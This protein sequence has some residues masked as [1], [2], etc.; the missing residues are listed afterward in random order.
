MPILNSIT[1]SLAISQIL[2]FAIFIAIHHR[3]SNIAK[4]LILFCVCF[5][6]YLLTTIPSIVSNAYVSFVLYRFAVAS[7]ALIWLVAVILFT[8]THRVPRGAIVLIALYMCANGTGAFLFYIQHEFRPTTF[9]LTFVIAQFI[10]L[11]FAVHA[12]YLG[13]T[14]KTADLIEAR[15]NVRLPFVIA[16][17]AL[18]AL[19]IGTGFL[20][21]ALILYPQG[22]D[23]SQA[24]YYSNTI[25]TTV[26]FLVCLLLNIKTFSLHS[27]ATIL[28][29]ERITVKPYDAPVPA[30]LRKS[31]DSDLIQRIKHTMEHEKLYREM[32]FTLGRLSEHLS[33][34]DY[35]LRRAIN[36]KLGF[37]NFNQFLNHFRIAEASEL[38]ER[39]SVP[40][41]T[42]ALNVG[43]ASL[44]SFNKAFKEQHGIP[45]RDYRVLDKVSESPKENAH[46]A[47]KKAD[48]ARNAS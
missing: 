28:L 6:S 3:E 22:N 2:F 48:Y 9:F 17:G 8:D 4:L 1:A 20:N 10:M 14:G 42:I 30:S 39:T 33:V 27:N 15:R 7:P 13:I 40:I 16:M 35:Q 11:G 21:Y 12:V 45:P 32:G 24:I 36:N 37:R 31:G 47:V 43:Y 5:G 46:A 26:A 38:L 23:P 34:Q 18:N 25:L 29:E 41:A 19:I 44:S